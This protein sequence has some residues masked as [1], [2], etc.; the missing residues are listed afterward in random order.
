[1]MSELRQPTPVEHEILDG[2]RDRA[3][4]LSNPLYMW[5]AYQFCRLRHIEHP[6]W[7]THY[8]AE[9]A[10]RIVLVG[11]E[12]ATKRLGN[13]EGQAWQDDI[14][15][16]LGF[17]KNTAGGRSDPYAAM[18][19]QVQ[20]WDYAMRVRVLVDAEDHNETDACYLVARRCGVSEATVSRAWKRF[21]DRVRLGDLGAQRAALDADDHD[22][23]PVPDGRVLHFQK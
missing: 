11:I 10:S 17:S 23:R 9:T 12:R 6:E 18:A 13:S 2:Y 22:L 14:I 3:E 16:A 8:L 7:L 15:G 20:S 4:Y 19:K 1:M 5:S 21:G